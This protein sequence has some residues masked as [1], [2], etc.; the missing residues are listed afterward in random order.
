[1]KTTANIILVAAAFA[2]TNAFAQ[3]P[4]PE[5]KKELSAAAGRFAKMDTDKDGKISLAEFTAAAKKP[6]N[7]SK[8]FTNRDTDKDGSLSEK[9]LSAKPA[10]GA[11]KEKPADE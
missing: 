9:E 6:E 4:N 2:T 8:A 7:A 5:P 10:G 1:M 11:K 3:Q